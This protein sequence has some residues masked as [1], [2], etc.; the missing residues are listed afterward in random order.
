[1]TPDT[2]K[3]STPPEIAVD[4]RFPARHGTKTTPLLLPDDGE[5]SVS[6]FLPADGKFGLLT[7]RRHSATGKHPF[8]YS[9]GDRLGL[10]NPKK[11]S[12]NSV[13]LLK[14]VPTDLTIKSDSV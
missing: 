8:P 11:L 6:L 12:I 10:R 7:I 1:M 13:H 9:Q 5:T 3:I 2:S 4:T 14:S